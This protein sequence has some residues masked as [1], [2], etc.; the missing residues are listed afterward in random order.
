MINTDCGTCPFKGIC[1]IPNDNISISSAPTEILK[2][3]F[4]RKLWK[5]DKSD[6]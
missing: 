3:F 4:A 5:R 2:R 1:P 6:V